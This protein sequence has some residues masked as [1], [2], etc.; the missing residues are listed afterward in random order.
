MMQLL[1]AMPGEL[2]FLDGALKRTA[3]AQAATDGCCVIALR[4]EE[5]ESLLL[6]DPSLVYK[7][8]RAIVRSAHGTV[9]TMDNVYSDLMHYISG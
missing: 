2:A 8:M 6:V 7:V 3:S 5:L 4:R 9:G 1:T